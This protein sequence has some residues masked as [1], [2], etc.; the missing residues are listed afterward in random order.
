MKVSTVVLAP[1]LLA[2]IANG[3]KVFGA[4]P[5]RTGTDSMKQALLDLGFGKPRTDKCN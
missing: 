4:G 2:G 1:L 5:G 3:L